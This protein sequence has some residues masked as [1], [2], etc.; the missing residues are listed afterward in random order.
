MD[1]EDRRSIGLLGFDEQTETWYIDIR[2]ARRIVLSRSSLESLVAIYNSIHTGNR[3]V[4]SDERS[5]RRI[6]GNNHDLLEAVRELH[7]EFD[8]RQQSL[9]HHRAIRF[10]VAIWR[11]LARRPSA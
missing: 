8:R 2:D 4:L 5:V 1:N 6:E 7:L 3:L 10:L 11:R 9:P